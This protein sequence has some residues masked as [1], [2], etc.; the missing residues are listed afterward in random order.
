MSML[1]SVL[2]RVEG[3]LELLTEL[4]EMFPECAEETLAE[5]SEACARRDA[6]AA[7][8]AAHTLKGMC[9]NLALE[10][11]AQLA[12]SLELASIAAQWDQ[13]AELLSALRGEVQREY[14]L[15]ASLV[16]QESS[17]ADSDR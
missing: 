12:K 11:S 8:A 7:R 15:L 5:L 4:V 10:Q 2:E 9:A 3:D 1:Q 17:R 6:H 13:C 14:E 16:R